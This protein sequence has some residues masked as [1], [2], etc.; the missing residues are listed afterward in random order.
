MIAAASDS[1]MVSRLTQAVRAVIGM[2]EAN[3]RGQ[4]VVD[5]ANMSALLGFNFNQGAGIG[6]SIYFPYT[7][8]GAVMLR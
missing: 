8:A 2:D 4:R 7:V 3:D 6:Q 1:R 5:K